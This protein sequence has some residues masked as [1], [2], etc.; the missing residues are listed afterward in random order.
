MSLMVRP[1]SS[2]AM[3]AAWAPSCGTV[4][5]GKR[6]NLIMSVPTTKTSVMAGLSARFCRSEEIREIG[7]AVLVLAPCVAKDD[8]DGHVELQR[9]GAGDDTG[10]VALHRAAAVEVDDGRNERHLD[11][12]KIPVHDREIV[13]LSRV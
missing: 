13:E 1:A 12:R 8:V 5:S 2:R 6:P 9:L 4:R 11:A 3:R 10:E 7:I